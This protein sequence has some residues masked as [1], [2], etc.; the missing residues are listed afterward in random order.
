ML[1]PAL[2]HCVLIVSFF[3]VKMSDA[4]VKGHSSDATLSA[5]VE[6]FKF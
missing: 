4:I 2:L 6:F 3:N 1:S 5:I